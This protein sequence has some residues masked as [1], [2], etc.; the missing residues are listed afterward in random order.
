MCTLRRRLY[1]FR[2]SFFTTERHDLAK[3]WQFLVLVHGSNVLFD[4]YKTINEAPSSS[5]SVCFDNWSKIHKR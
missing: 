3:N 4:L 2:E 5:M 1:G